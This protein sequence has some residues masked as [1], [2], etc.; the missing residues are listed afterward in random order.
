MK[1]LVEKGTWQPTGYA[2]VPSLVQ[3]AKALAPYMLGG[4]AVGAGLGAS[5]MFENM[6]PMSGAL[7]FALLGG[8][9]S[10]IPQIGNF[11]GKAAMT[12]ASLI[13]RR[14]IAPT[15]AL[16]S[17]VGV[18]PTVQAAGAK[19]DDAGFDAYFDEAPSE[20]QED[21]FDAYFDEA[22]ASPGQ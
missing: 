17:N 11:K 20:G 21:E 18:S 7:G 1:N 12:A 10:A 5:G 9:L 15:T 16:M 14:T 3:D 8:G 2:L 6:D 22:P 13:P 4:S 19:R